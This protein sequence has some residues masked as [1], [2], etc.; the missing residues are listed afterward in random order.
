MSRSAMK[1]ADPS[2]AD[3]LI[4]TAEA[5]FGE[6]GLEGVSLRQI[7]LSA[8]TGNNNAVQYHFGDVS[9]LIRAILEKRIPEIEA[10]RAE[11]LAKAKEEGRLS[12]TSSLMDMTFRPLFE[13][14]D[15]RGQR[16]YARFILALLKSPTR[17]ERSASTRVPPSGMEVLRLIYAANP[18]I[19]PLLLRE[20]LR[21]ILCMVLTSFFDRH[22]LEDGFDEELIDNAIDM[23]TAALQVPMGDRV[24]AMMDQIRLMS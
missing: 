10:R 11:L 5:L 21:Q 6:H 8:G 24:R 9:G 23:A 16:T 2:V 3:R 19:P 12:E 1:R 7:S 17:P 4:E 13:H 15:A 18:E 14:V 22:Y 20:R